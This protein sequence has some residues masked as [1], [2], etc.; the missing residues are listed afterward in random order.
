M[1]TP[2]KSRENLGQKFQKIPKD[3]IM[4]SK[5]EIADKRRSEIRYR[6]WNKKKDEKYQKVVKRGKFWKNSKNN[7]T[8]IW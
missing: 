8:I 5:S 6:N 1:S 3:I 7:I 4:D 2:V